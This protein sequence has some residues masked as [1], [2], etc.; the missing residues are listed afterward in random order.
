MQ[1]Y[2]PR[3]RIQKMF[4]KADPP[5]PI[6]PKVVEH[7]ASDDELP[8]LDAACENGAWTAPPPWGGGAFRY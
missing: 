2:Q 7:D 6:P 8:S 5:N 3:T 1:I 4:I